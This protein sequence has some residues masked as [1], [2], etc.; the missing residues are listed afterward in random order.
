VTT[1]WLYP[2][3]SKANYYF[4]LSRSSTVDTSPTSFEEMIHDGAGDDEW[5][6]FKNWKSAAPGDRVWIYYGTADGDLGVVG[7]ATIRRVVPPSEPGAPGMVHLR[8]QPKVTKRL[9]RYPYPAAMVRE[10]LHHPRGAMWRI[11]EPLAQ[12]LV[13]H[14]KGAQSGPPAPTSQPS[15]GQ[16]RT[17]V[18]SY[19]PPKVVKARLRHDAL[20][21]PLMVRL[22]ASGWKSIHFDVGSKHVDLAMA[23]RKQIVLVEAKTVG[24]STLLACR[25]AFAQLCEYEWR[26]RKSTGSDSKIHCWA[27]FEREPSL[28]EVEFLEDHGILVS[29][30]DKHARRFAHGARTGPR[31]AVLQ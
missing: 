11:P 7:L 9:L 23:R 27:V 17:A 3:S 19:R 16:G 21:R 14:S 28:D 6:V 18:I 2:L 20:L 5:G 31:T 24:S 30:A 22:G 10:H 12:Q 15:Y 29:W 4:E 26:Y 1:D 8:W 13:R 25:Q